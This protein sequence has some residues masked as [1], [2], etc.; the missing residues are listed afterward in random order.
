MSA[1]DEAERGPVTVPLHVPLPDVVEGPGGPLHRWRPGD[2]VV[3]SE[4]VAA[5]V[6]HLK[7]VMAF[8]WEEPI[9]LAARRALLASWDEEWR[10]GTLGPYKVPDDG[11]APCGVISLNRGGAPQ[12]LSIGYWIA[13]TEEGRGRVTQAASLLTAEALAHDEV[14]TV[15]IAHDAANKRSAAVPRRLGFARRGAVTRGAWA[16]GGPFVSVRWEA[17]RSWHPPARHASASAP[18]PSRSHERT[19]PPRTQ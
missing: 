1:P 3:L 7:S 13:P 10:R 17:D 18:D 19:V 15:V 11:G 8:A 2:E 5:S 14:D 16:G 4:L 12:E 9:D 6:A